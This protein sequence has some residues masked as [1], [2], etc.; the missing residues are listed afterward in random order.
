[1][2][3]DFVIILALFLRRKT[4]N[5]LPENMNRAG[6]RIRLF[7]LP[8]KL[9]IYFAIFFTQPLLPAILYTPRVPLLS[10]KRYTS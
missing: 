2:M 1:M 9:Y 3:K 4:R 8:G 7:S 10:K 6:E 5:P